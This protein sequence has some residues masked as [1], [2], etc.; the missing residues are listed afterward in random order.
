MY[1]SDANGLETLEL[2][3]FTEEPQHK[4]DV[5]DGAVYKDATTRLGVVYKRA[6]LVKE[7]GSLRTKDDGGAVLAFCDQIMCFTIGGVEPAGERTHDFLL[8]I[9]L[10]GVFVCLEDGPGL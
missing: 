3:V 2:A 1:G 4:V 8:G 6:R 7:V 9:L 5:M 10:L